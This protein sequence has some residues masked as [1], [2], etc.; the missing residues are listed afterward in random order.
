MDTPPS[1]V[2]RS[3]PHIAFPTDSIERSA[4]LVEPVF[5]VRV[6]AALRSTDGEEFFLP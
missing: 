6:V 1:R 2:Q 3:P 5:Q 4:V